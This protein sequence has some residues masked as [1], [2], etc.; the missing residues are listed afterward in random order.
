MSIVII[1]DN[2]TTHIKCADNALSAKKPFC[3]MEDL[4]NNKE[5]LGKDYDGT[6]WQ[7]PHRENLNG[8]C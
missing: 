1:F 7:T 6:E 5:W 2:A 3:N 8:G 4:Q